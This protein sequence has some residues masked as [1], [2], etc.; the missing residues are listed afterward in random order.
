[1]LAWRM[2]L[3]PVLIAA[4]IGLFVADAR[5]GSTAPFLFCLAC[6]VA[7]RGTW[8]LVQLLR[9]R[10]ELNF[11]LLAGVSLAIVAANWLTAVPASPGVGAQGAGRLG[12]P[13]LLYVLAGLA[14][15]VRALARYRAPGGNIELLSAE[16][17]IVTYIGAFLSPMVQLRWID[18]GLG[19]VPFASLIVATKCGDT[20][21]YFAGHLFGRTK[22]APLISPGKTRAGALGALVGAALGSWAWLAYGTFWLTNAVPGAWYWSVLYGLILGLTGL[23]GDLAESLL[24][25]DVQVKDSAPLLPGFG[26]L[27]DILDS[28]LFAGPVAYA[29]WLVLPLTS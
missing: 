20:C 29:L 23:V 17:L 2:F 11:A 21:A 25:R 12:L 15:F 26:G 18:L 10:F 19:Y 16:L 9:G 6:F 5:A 14:L 24:K 13:M 7:V 22:L 8:E 1:M 4:F 27:L 3:G 28:I